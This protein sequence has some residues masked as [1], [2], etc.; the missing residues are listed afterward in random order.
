MKKL[1]AFALGA[2]ML[3]AIGFYLA[4]CIKFIKEYKT[5]RGWAIAGIVMSVLMTATIVV[6]F[7]QFSKKT[8]AATK[9]AGAAATGK[10]KKGLGLLKDIGKG[11]GTSAIM[12]AGKNTIDTAG[13]VTGEKDEGMPLD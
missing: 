9:Q 4:D 1:I 3:V 10:S 5:Q 8:A 7:F 2:A 12:D 6:S 11:I 13:K